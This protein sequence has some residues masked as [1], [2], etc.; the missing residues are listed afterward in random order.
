[1]ASG[2]YRNGIAASESKILFHKDGKTAS[3]DLVR[4]GS[5]KLSIL[6][7]GKP[8]AAISYSNI[9]SPDEM[10]MIRLAALPLAIHSNAKTVANIGFGSGLTSHLLLMDPDIDEVDIVEI[11]PAIVE[12]AKGFGERVANNYTDPRS[13]IY[14]E[15]AKT[16]FTNAGKQYDLI[17]S[18]PSNPW[19]SGVAG[20]FSKEFYRLIR[21]YIKDD[22]LLVQWMHLYEMDT[23]L[24]ASI[25]KALSENFV[26][27]SIYFTGDQNIIILAGK[28]QINRQLSDRIFTIPGLK[29]ELARV[30]I[31]GKQDLQL[32]KLGSKK[33]LDPLFNSYDIPANS[34]YFPILDIRAVKARYLKSDATE[35][36]RIRS[37][38]MTLLETLANDTALQTSGFGSLP[39]N[40]ILSYRA[41]HGK[42]IFKYFR[43]LEDRNNTPTIPMDQ[44]TTQIVRS[45]RL[46]REK[47][48][49]KDIIENWFPSISYLLDLTLPYLSSQEMKMIWSDIESAPCFSN[50]PPEIMN[51]VNLY[52]SLGSR[53]FDQ[54]L[55]ISTQLLPPGAIKASRW[56]D[57]FLM[58]A[59]L[60]NLALENKAAAVELWSRYENKENP[61][62]YLRLLSAVLKQ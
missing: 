5:G 54:V 62:I 12:A 36:V 40:S 48:E 42:A 21:N 24:I 11:E 46:I 3:V 61:I 23:P 26:D 33:T 44:K 25:I 52:R 50:I 10:T 35:W 7:N 43:Y 22:G 39:E 19:V 15:D 13:H 27:Y 34:D 17:I 49:T 56:N 30:K 20:L 9:A 31:F 60:A 16:F 1:M 57:Y 59:M 32:R 55:K 51:L 38:P 18:E 2:V 53:D 6:T 8:D 47:C 14:F 37:A 45:F 58:A 29:S 28:Q 4:N 41:H